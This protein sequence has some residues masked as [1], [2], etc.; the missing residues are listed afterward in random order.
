MRRTMLFLAL[1]LVATSLATGPIP[2]ASAATPGAEAALT[3]VTQIEAGDN[4]TCAVLTNGQARCWGYNIFRQLGNGLL[5]STGI[6]NAV[7]TPSG[8]GNLTGVTQVSAGGNHSCA[9]LS[10]GQLRCWGFNGD[11]AL[12]AND[13][14]PH[15]LA[16]VVKAVGGAGRLTGVVQ[17][18]AGWNHTCARVTGGQVRCWGGNG[19]GQVGDDS[20]TQR[21]APVVVTA[22]TGSGPLTGVT[23]IAAGLN[24]NCA[25]R[26]DGRVVCWGNGNSAQ[27]GDGF[28]SDR[29][30]PVFVR[31]SDNSGQLTG[32]RQV[33]VGDFY[34]CALLTSG[35]ARCWGAAPGGTS[36]F[37]LAVLNANST[38]LTGITSIAA[39]T[40]HVC[41]RLSNGRLRC[42]GD[43][44]SGQ[45]GDLTLTPRPTPVSMLNTAATAPV[46]GVTS[47]AAGARHTCARLTTAQVICTGTN[48]NGQLG[49][50]PGPGTAR[51][52]GV[53]R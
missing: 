36:A 4:H 26:S 27:L 53:R 48:D 45:L 25:R 7:L 49:A 46:T 41:F 13:E 44:A 10:S 18:A 33:A 43:N 51:P 17:V 37:P 14:D 42:R 9:R 29:D 52:I 30:R 34:A 19:D 47:V 21:N 40:D 3:G 35:Q 24:F 2:A 5:T 15:N 1:T 38:P 28:A 32:V 20:T 12:G 11:G 16:M 50:G 8:T 22:P 23:Q 31:N 39:G 6:P